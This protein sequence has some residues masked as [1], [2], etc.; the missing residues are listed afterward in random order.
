MSLHDVPLLQ[1][2]VQQVNLVSIIF[3]KSSKQKYLA[4]LIIKNGNSLWSALKDSVLPYKATSTNIHSQLLSY[5]T[6]FKLATRTQIHQTTKINSLSNF[7]LYGTMSKLL[8][9]LLF[10]ALKARCHSGSL[11]L[12][13]GLTNARSNCLRETN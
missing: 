13:Y 3:G 1:Y 9:M 7:P 12:G 11:N 4:I 2:T 10:L 8:C 5:F 6:I